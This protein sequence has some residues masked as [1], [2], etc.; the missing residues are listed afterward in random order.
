MDIDTAIRGGELAAKIA[1]MTGRLEAIKVAV[2]GNYSISTLRA[3]N[4]AG[5]EVNLLSEPLGSK[6]SSGALEYALQIC[7]EQ[8][9]VL[10]KELKAL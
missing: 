1:A 8:L 6:L 3:V 4:P 9:D 2:D 10:H 7:Q 5:G